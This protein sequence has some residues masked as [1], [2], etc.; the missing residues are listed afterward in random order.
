VITD[1]GSQEL[2]EPVVPADSSMTHLSSKELELIK[3]YGLSSTRSYSQA[4]R[5]PVTDDET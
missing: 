5:K 3:K 4:S 2:P 1:D